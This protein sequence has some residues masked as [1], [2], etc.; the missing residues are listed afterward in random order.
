LS[1]LSNQVEQRRWSLEIA[2]R[3]LNSYPWTKQWMPSR[4]RR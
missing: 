3:V 2:R 4:F 1:A